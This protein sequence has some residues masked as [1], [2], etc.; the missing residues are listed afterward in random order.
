LKRWTI[1]PP[2]SPRLARARIEADGV[3]PVIET[4]SFC[5]TS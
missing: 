5:P 1:T 4:T 3:V 2:I